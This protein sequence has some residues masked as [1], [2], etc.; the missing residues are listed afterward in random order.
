MKATFRLAATVCAIVFA[1]SLAPAQEARNTRPFHEGVTDAASLKRIV[2]GQLERANLLLT[3]L[4]SV[5]GTRT[6]ENTLQ[7]YDDL[8]G[9]LGNAFGIVF[10]MQRLHPDAGVRAAAGAS[11]GGLQQFAAT[12]GYNR[13][14]FDA[15]AAIDRQTLQEEAL[16]H[17]IET[18][19]DTFRRAGVEQPSDVR[20]KLTALQAQLMATSVEFNRNIQTG[21]RNIETNMA[22]LEGVPRDFLQRFTP[23]ARGVIVVPTVQSDVQTIVEFA[24]SPDLRKRAFVAL[25][26]VAHPENA[27]VLQRLLATRFEIARLLGY[28][29]WAELDMAPRMTGRSAAVATFIDQIAAASEPRAR[30]EY[31]TLLE[32]KRKDDSSAAAVE[33]WEQ[34]FYQ[35]LIRRERYDLDQQLVRQY[36]PA[37]H[38]IPGV[39]DI[40]SRL[41]G[42]TFRRV[43]DVPVWHPSVQVYELAHNGTA[44]GRCYLDLYPRANK[45]GS[46]ASHAGVRTG[47]SRQMPE[48]V[49]T[50]ALPGGVESDPGL[51]S[52]AEVRTLFHELGH[53]VHFMSASRSPWVGLNGLPTQADANEVTSTLAEEWIMD[54][55]TLQTFARH[56]QTGEPIPAQLVERIR[57]ASEFGLGLNLRRQLALAKTSL[58]L[59]TQS[60]EGVN[61]DA[62]MADTARQYMPLL[63]ISGTHMQSGW[64]HLA[65]PN[66]A[67]AYYT[68]EW[69]RVIA[70]DLFTKFDRS[71]LLA[72]EPAGR[73]RDLVMTPGK[74][75]RA[76][77]LFEDFLGRPFS[78]DAWGRWVNEGAK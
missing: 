73:L 41:Y 32:R 10:T 35:S 59:H 37:K 38:V 61:P 29:H 53:L 60:P 9:H 62:V 42:I 58:L 68:Y 64:T 26:N 57:R 20:A 6:V 33:E 54:T 43:D 3:Q 46:G 25:R 13:D 77:Q 39:L 7:P 8:S 55:R 28:P 69:S 71:N 34:S 50:A 2:D 70:K 47:S 52:H 48:S 11:M 22:E 74:S 45:V 72:P 17:Y 31:S 49:I 19:L 51:M 12:I 67:S 27:A 14:L 18:D 36:F 16:K 40:I 63:Q 15:L 5:K 24:R 1:L 76:A 4:L 75:K 66:Y 21:N 44:L 23:D 78:A 65:N 30:A 56:Y